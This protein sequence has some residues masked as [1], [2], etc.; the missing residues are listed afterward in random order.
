[1]SG[2]LLNVFVIGLSVTL[3]DFASKFLKFTFHVYISF[4]WLG[5]FTLVLE[6]FFLFH[7]SFIAYH[8]IRDCRSST[9][10]YVINFFLK[11]I[12]FVLLGMLY[13][14]QCVHS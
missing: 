8:D 3:R 4:S 1:M 9:K 13:V 5:A 14:V 7:G 12:L 2:W 11:C 10:F 6:V